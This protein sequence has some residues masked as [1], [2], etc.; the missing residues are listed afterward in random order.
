MGKRTTYWIGPYEFKFK[1]DAEAALRKI[2]HQYKTTPGRPIAVEDEDILFEALKQHPQ[3]AEKI[4]AGIQH[5]FVDLTE[6]GTPCFHLK[7][8]DGSTTDWSFKEVLNPSTPDRKFLAACCEAVA[9]QK[10]AFRDRARGGEDWPR[11]AQGQLLPLDQVDVDHVE[12]QF[13][14]IVDSFIRENSI[15][16][17]ET[18]FL[19]T[20]DHRTKTEFTDKGLE[21]RFADY[22]RVVARLRVISSFE[23]RR[24]KRK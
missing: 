18:G 24:R 1:K 17:G 5:F 23:N 3:S 10:F 2:L 22:H 6:Y 12:P 4:G 14:E 13:R 9:E 8:V 21:A 19:E 7:R 11:G 20:G 15:D 16:V